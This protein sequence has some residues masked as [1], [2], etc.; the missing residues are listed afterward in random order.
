M[1][2]IILFLLLAV[3]A[4]RAD[5]H[6]SFQLDAAAKRK[7]VERTLALKVG[8]SYDSVTN[9]LGVPTID[10][11]LMKKETNRIVG[12]SLTYYAVIWERGS[13]NELNDEFV[14]VSLDER[15]RV[16]SVLIRINLK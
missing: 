8:D 10:Q 1:K 7:L 6:P 12:R 14:D 5:Q 3:S 2:N 4:V 15:N 16:S 9:A 11:T 13:V